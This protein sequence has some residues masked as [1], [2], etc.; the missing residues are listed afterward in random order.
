MIYLH[1][2][3]S[4]QQRAISSWQGLLRLDASERPMDVCVCTFNERDLSDDNQ[5]APYTGMT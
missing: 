3:I 2:H 4:I 5:H 1:T